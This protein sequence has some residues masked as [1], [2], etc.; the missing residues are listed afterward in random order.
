VAARAERAEARRAEA[1]EQE[2]EAREEMAVKE[3]EEQAGPAS[4]HE[5]NSGVERKRRS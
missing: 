1:E 2:R 3:R 5:S 4:R